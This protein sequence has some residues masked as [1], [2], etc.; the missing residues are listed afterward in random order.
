MEQI[1]KKSKFRK[2]LHGVYW[3]LCL[4][5]LLILLWGLFVEPNRLVIRR[6]TVAVPGLPREFEGVRAGIVADT[7]FGNSFI[8]KLRRDRIV[9]LFQRE[10]PDMGFLLGDYVAVGALPHYG[11]LKEEEFVRFFS[12]LK[13]PLGTYAVLGNHELWY[14]RKRMSALLE[15]SG[16]QVIEN[17]VFKVKNLTL[18]GLQDYS[19]APFER[20]EM[21]RFLNEHRP[22]IVLTHKGEILKYAEETPL[23]TVFAADTHGGQVRIPGKYALRYLFYKR[24]ELAPGLSEVWGRKLF[25][26]T[27]AGGH[28]LNFR[29]FCPP[30]IAIVTFKGEIAEK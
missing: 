19:I 17:K 2:V 10:K 20:K 6:C 9:R 28:R 27:G 3:T 23:F 18:A 29:L 21:N 7:H 12:A 4:I 14:G 8:D 15:K 26:T 11:T 16:V 5:A 30:E 13:T 22:H 24:K 25:V 1:Q